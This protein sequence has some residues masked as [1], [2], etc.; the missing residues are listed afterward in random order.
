MDNYLSVPYKVDS[1]IIELYEKV[2]EKNYKRISVL[3]RC[4]VQYDL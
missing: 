3:N 1:E 2:K 4:G